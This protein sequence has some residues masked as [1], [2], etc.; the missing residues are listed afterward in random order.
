MHP[1]LLITRLIKYN[2]NKIFTDKF[3]D[4]AVRFF[5]FTGKKGHYLADW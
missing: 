5:F 3:A 2:E 4:P 1:V